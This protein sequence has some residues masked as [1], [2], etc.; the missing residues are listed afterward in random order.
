ML[1]NK[2]IFKQLFINT[3][4]FVPL[5]ALVSCGETKKETPIVKGGSDTQ[6]Q[7]QQQPGVQVTDPKK[8]EAQNKY[9]TI[10]TEYQ[11]IKNEKLKEGT[12]PLIKSALDTLLPKI[13]EILEKD[14]FDHVRAQTYLD[15]VKDK[16]VKFKAAIVILT[17]EVAQDKYNE[18]NSEYESVK[19]KQLKEN[20]DPLIKSA[21]DTLLPKIK[22]ILEKDKFDYV[23]AQTYLDVVKDRLAKFKEAIK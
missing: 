20:T 16:L 6:Q 17:K 10:N 5:V 8:E 23:R 13:K 4:A 3:I 19:N 15:V 1:K 12:D 18:I 21:L 7:Q 14:K 2:T 9:N 11:Y 22:E